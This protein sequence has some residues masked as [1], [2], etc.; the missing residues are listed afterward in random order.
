MRNNLTTFCRPAIVQHMQNGR[1]DAVI[2][3][4]VPTRTKQELIRLAKVY[5]VSVST[6]IRVYTERYLLEQ[7]ERTGAA[8]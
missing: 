3:V 4:A 8:R 2:H 1:K 5:D 7:R 6:L